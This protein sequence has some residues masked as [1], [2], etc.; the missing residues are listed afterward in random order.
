MTALT[1][2]RS[3]PIKKTSAVEFTRLLNALANDVIDAHLHWRMITD[4]RAAHKQYPLVGLQSQTFWHLTRKA[5]IS[6]CLLNLCRVFD[7]TKKTLNLFSWLSTIECNLAMFDVLEFKHR[8]HS[9]PFVESLAENAKRPNPSD[10]HA[11]MALC[12]LTDPLVAKLLQYRHNY[13]AHRSATLSRKAHPPAIGMTD[14]IFEVLLERASRIL[15][16]YSHLFAA[17]TFSMR[18]HGQQDFKYIF[19]TV[20]AAVDSTQAKYAGD[21]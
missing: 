17:V 5:H 2:P 8:L 15:N 1:K 13:V 18:M 11:D 9:N 3:D 10:L 4:L 16:H 6:A 21:Q 7:R 19:T 14:E 20:E 12:E